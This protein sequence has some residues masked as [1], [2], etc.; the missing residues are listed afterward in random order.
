MRT[1]RAVQ[2]LI[3]CAPGAIQRDRMVQ[4]ASE[5]LGLS[6]AALRRD[7]A[8]KQQARPAPRSTAAVEEPAAP[9]PVRRPQAEVSLI[10]MLCLYPEEVFPIV[11]DHLP[12]EY[13]TDPDCR[14]IFDMLLNH[15]ENLMDQLPS[16]RP[17]LQ[18]LAV[19][20]QMKDSRIG[21]AYEPSEAAQQYVMSLWR[22]ALEKKRKDVS[23]GDPIRLT[24]S[25][26]LVRLRKG[27]EYA[28]DFLVV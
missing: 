5:R 28:V 18:K 21:K 20:I 27:W 3:A 11:A 8:R 19:Q 2:T 15:P 4:R 7:M 16:D 6:P 22:Q 12:S 14:Y 26:Q 13:L 17:E 1:S 24:I 10:Q 23:T 25:D 9:A